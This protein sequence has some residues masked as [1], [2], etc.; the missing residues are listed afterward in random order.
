MALKHEQRVA[1]CVNPYAT[2]REQGHALI[3]AQHNIGFLIR[4]KFTSFIAALSSGVFSLFPRRTER[5]E[6]VP[7]RARECEDDSNRAAD[8]SIAEIGEVP[9]GQQ[10][11]LG[12]MSLLSSTVFH[13]LAI[14]LC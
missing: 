9:W 2:Q 12:T 7:N 1:I 4:M 14:T 11:R 13:Q 5:R 8:R 3:D 6:D 10:F